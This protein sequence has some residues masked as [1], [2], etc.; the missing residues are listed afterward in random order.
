[1]NLWGIRKMATKKQYAQWC[2]DLIGG[3]TYFLETLYEELEV[4]GFVD[5]DHEWIYEEDE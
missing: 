3:D 5:E 1:M 4:D 2:Y